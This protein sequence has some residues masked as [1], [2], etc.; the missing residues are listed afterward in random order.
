M[1]LSLRPIT[2]SSLCDYKIRIPQNPFIKITGFTCPIN[3]AM[4]KEIDIIV[5]GNEVR[6]DEGTMQLEQ[7]S[8]YLARESSANEDIRIFISAQP[9]ATAEEFYNVLEIIQKM[10]VDVIWDVDGCRIEPP[11]PVYACPGGN[12]SSL[13]NR[14]SSTNSIQQCKRTR[15]C[16]DHR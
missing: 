12:S 8:D 16:C 14:K 11:Q 2:Q 15:R 3:F 6:V 1:V 5:L 9:D 4:A 10:T 13:F 7:L